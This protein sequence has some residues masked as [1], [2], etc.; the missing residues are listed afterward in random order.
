MLTPS[1]IQEES[2]LT[3]KALRS[4]TA[5]TKHEDAVRVE[6]RKLEE[7]QWEEVEEAAR[8]AARSQKSR[9]SNQTSEFNFYQAT[10]S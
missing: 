7:G 4:T 10:T 6:K 8:L 3:L 2:D 5:K 9:R 1:Q